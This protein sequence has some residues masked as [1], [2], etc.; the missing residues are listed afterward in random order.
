[1]YNVALLEG[2]NNVYNNRWTSNLLVIHEMMGLCCLSQVLSR[3]IVVWV[4]W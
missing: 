2:L 4:M 1:M 3:V